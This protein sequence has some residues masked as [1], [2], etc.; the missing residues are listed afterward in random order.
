LFYDLKPGEQKILPGKRKLWKQEV[1]LSGLRLTDAALLV[2]AMDELVAAPSLT[3]AR[4]WGMV[5]FAH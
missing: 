3:Y 1:Y 5:R 2:V 4:L